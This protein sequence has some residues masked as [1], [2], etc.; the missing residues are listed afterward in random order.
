MVIKDLYYTFYCGDWYPHMWDF[1]IM[2][3]IYSRYVYIQDKCMNIHLYPQVQ[4]K[5]TN[6]CDLDTKIYKYKV[7]I[8]GI[9]GKS[10]WREIGYNSAPEP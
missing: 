10:I 7:H 5:H 2:S 8:V 3:W 9:L 1:L 6:R 4:V